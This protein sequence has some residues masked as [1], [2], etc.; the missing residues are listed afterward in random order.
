MNC[1]VVQQYARHVGEKKCM[2]IVVEHVEEHFLRRT[3]L[4]VHTGGPAGKA[5]CW[6]GTRD[7]RREQ[8]VTPSCSVKGEK[9][10][11][12]EEAKSES[13]ENLGSLFAPV[14]AR[15]LLLPGGCNKPIQH[16]DHDERGGSSPT[17]QAL[18]HSR[19][20]K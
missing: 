17:F 7:P 4:V 6:V 10:E 16:A 12:R 14:Y 8:A 9:M 13:I 3:L 5:F 2:V 20:R 11:T 19:G 18:R 15:L 1:A